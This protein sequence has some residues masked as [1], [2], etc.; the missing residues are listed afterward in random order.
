MK[1]LAAIL[2]VCG[3][4]GL[5]ASALAEAQLSPIP[6]AVLNLSATGTLLESKAA[7]AVLL[8]D[9]NLSASPSIILLDRLEIAKIMS[10]QNLGVSGIIDPATAAQAGHIL[11]ARLLITGRFLHDGKTYLLMTKII[12]SETGRVYNE[13]V[14]FPDLDHL[15][16]SVRILSEKIQK[17]ISAKR[18]LLL[19]KIETPEERLA[20]WRKTVKAPLPRV[21][22]QVV[23]CRTDSCAQDTFSTQLRYF[24][25]EL[26]FPVLDPSSPHSPDI[27]ITGETASTF[28]GRRSDIISYRALAIT[29]V[30]R[31]SDQKTLLDAR[32]VEPCV[33]LSDAAA[34]SGA[35]ESAAAKLM[36]QLIPVLAHP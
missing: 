1:P 13:T 17:T 25:T 24:L 8:L 5:P 20:R 4:W 2:G 11:G 6:T 22:I 9:A 29:K 16:G 12:S 28:T 30:Q 23:D 19:A 32:I 35:L 18:A 15:P 7:E 21:S 36:D 31:N 10:E 14:D 26:G 3:L 33:A 27:T 34:K